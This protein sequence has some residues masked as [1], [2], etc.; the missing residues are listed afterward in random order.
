MADVKLS[1]LRRI[2]QDYI[3][4]TGSNDSWVATQMGISRQ[5]LNA[6]WTKGRA[7]IPGP[8][9]LHSLAVTTKTP[10]RDVLD[11]ALN[12]FG[13][14]PESAAAEAEPTARMS[15]AGKSEGRARRAA[16]NLAATAPDAEGPELGA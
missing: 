15:R 11:A 12:D 3:D 6:W 9:L 14:L 2:V 10:Y 13:Y 16:Q 5:E 1:N 8:F 7:T 4:S